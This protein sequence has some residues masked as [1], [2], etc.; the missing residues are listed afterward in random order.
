MSV[1]TT[2]TIGNLP[3]GGSNR[4]DLVL[5]TYIPDELTTGTP[6]GWTPQGTLTGDQVFSTPGQTI[7]DQL[8]VGNVDIRAANVTIERCEIQG[9]GTGGSRGI[10]QCR[11][12]GVT[13]PAMIKDC[14]IW[15]PDGGDYVLD[16]ILGEQFTAFRNHIKYVIDGIGG[17]PLSGGSPTNTL[18]QANLIEQGVW[19]SNAPNHSDG[20]HNDGIQIQGGGG[21]VGTTGTTIQYNTIRGVFAPASVGTG[22]ATTTQSLSCIMLNNNVGNLTGLLIDSNWLYAGQIALNGGG[23]AAAVTL[24]T[25]SNNKFDH[26]QLY[27][28]ANYDDTHTIDVRN[29]PTV[30]FTNNTYVDNGVAVHVRRTTS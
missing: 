16:G 10:V 4:D 25:I 28:G 15:A 1:T 6:P 7:S 27:Q 13:S 18:I 23:L 29:I 12:V 14:L 11:H 24:G 5:G 19:W 26:T 9:H 30:T 8:I 22:D 17:I 3:P 20:S 2:L 21:T